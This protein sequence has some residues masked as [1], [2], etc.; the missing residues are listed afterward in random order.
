MV[1]SNPAQ[2]GE[3][4]E[5]LHCG[6]LIVKREVRREIPQL[7][8]IRLRVETDVVDGYLHISAVGFQQT[9]GNTQESAFPRPVGSRDHQ[10]L[11]VLNIATYIPDNLAISEFFKDTFE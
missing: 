7:S 10:H 5:I 11:S 6:K 9:G 3:E 1:Q 8:S 2:G 4:Q